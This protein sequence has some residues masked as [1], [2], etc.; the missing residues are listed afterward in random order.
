[1]SLQQINIASIYNGPLPKRMAQCTPDMAS[2]IYLLNQA[3]D[4]RL[5]LSDMFRSHDM[6]FQAHLDYTSGKKKAF[7]PPPGGSM[8]EAGRAMDIDLTCIAPLSLEDFWNIAKPLGF[9]PIID[10]PNIR[11]S[12]AWH[13]DFR[14]SF[15]IVY[16]YAKNHNNKHPYRIMSS[17]AIL[18]QDIDVD[19]FEGKEDAYEIQSALIRLGKDIGPIDGIVG[20]KCNTAMTELNCS[21]LQ[22]LKVLIKR[23]YPNEY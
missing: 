11:T 13:F 12:E 10:Q 1:M 9:M 2:A 23:A 3:L 17:L 16:N 21:T 4:N 19:E 20:N 7:S 8:H 5:V 6:Q 18:D 14:G 15:Q 22:D